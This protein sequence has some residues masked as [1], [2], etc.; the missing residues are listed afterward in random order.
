MGRYCDVWKGEIQMKHQIQWFGF[1]A[2]FIAVTVV[3]LGCV[4]STWWLQV[5]DS[6]SRSELIHKAVLS[7]EILALGRPNA[8]LSEKLGRGRAVAFLGKKT[9]TYYTKAVRFWSIYQNSG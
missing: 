8:A 2:V 7:D 4:T 6:A 5:K 1:V 9:P 3:T